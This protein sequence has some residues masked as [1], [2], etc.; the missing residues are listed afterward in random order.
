MTLTSVSQ[1][2][3]ASALV[4]VL[5]VIV[6]GG[7]V[8]VVQLRSADPLPRPAQ[9]KSPVDADTQVLTK[10]TPTPDSKPYR[11]RHAAGGDRD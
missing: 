11:G 3:I 1:A 5:V 8:G 6:V 4:A 7:I 9:P 2:L 10:P